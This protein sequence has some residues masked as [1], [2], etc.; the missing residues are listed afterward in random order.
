[1]KLVYTDEAIGDLKRLRQFIAVHNPTAASRVAAELISEIQ[2]LPAFP[3]L[4]TPVAL[5]PVPDVI[6]DI[7]FGHYVVR[8]SLHTS[9][10]IILRVWHGLENER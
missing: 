6:R 10:I 4:G 1:M 5:A 8:Y 3:K 7:I 9:T 2:L